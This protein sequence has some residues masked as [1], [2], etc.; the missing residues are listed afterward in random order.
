MGARFGAATW[1]HDVPRTF[2]YPISDVPRGA[3]VK[4]AASIGFRAPGADGPTPEQRVSTMWAMPARLETWL[5][6]T[7]SSSALGPE[8]SIRATL[9]LPGL[10]A[11]VTLRHDPVLAGAPPEDATV[12][13]PMVA[14]GERLC[15][16]GRPLGGIPAGAPLTLRVT[17]ADGRLLADE[18]ELGVCEDGLHGAAVPCVVG[19]SAVSRV[20]GLDWSAR[21]GPRVR[22]H[23]A[24]EFARGVLVFL[25]FRRPH[26]G[27]A[28]LEG[29]RELTLVEP[30]RALDGPE[31]TLEGMGPTGTW[32]SVRFNEP[33]GRP[34]GGEHVVGRCVVRS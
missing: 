19:A 25:G 18:H 22:V 8:V 23:G 17:D 27:H 28:P 14:T 32:V 30:G 13:V 24:L 33:T 2:V 26:D 21:R 5:R 12:R 3:A 11:R 15:A 31:Q 9:V 4:R 20:S 6:V 10:Q 16:A 7:Q 29:V 1:R 34:I